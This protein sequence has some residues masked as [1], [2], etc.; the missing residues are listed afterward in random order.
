MILAKLLGAHI[1]CEGGNVFLVGSLHRDCST[2]SRIWSSES[3]PS[4]M[5]RRVAAF[6]V[7]RKVELNTRHEDFCMSGSEYDRC[8]PVVREPGTR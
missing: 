4:T 7:S 5:E 1:V 3:C 8:C 6:D 2:F